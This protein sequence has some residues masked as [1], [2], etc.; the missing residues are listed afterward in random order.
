MKALSHYAKNNLLPHL[1]Y[2]AIGGLTGAGIGYGT[3]R[4]SNEP[5]RQQ[6]Q[7]LQAIDPKERTFQQAKDLAFKQVRLTAGEWEETHPRESTLL[8]AL[9]GAGI[10][11]GG[12][13]SAVQAVKDTPKQLDRIQ[14]IFEAIKRVKKG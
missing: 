9:I 14:E 6:V 7:E 13:P 11:V 8:G 3:S 2:A 1:P 4:M 5:L 12:G 10:G